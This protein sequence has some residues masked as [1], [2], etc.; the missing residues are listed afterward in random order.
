MT[1]QRW[2]SFLGHWWGIRHSK[3]DGSLEQLFH[4]FALIEDSDWAAVG[5]DQLL[6]RVDAERVEDRIRDIRGRYRALRGECTVLV[7]LAQHQPGLHPGPREEQRRGLTPVVAPRVLV[8][9][10]RA[11]EVAHHDQ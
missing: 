9:L 1:K 4:R 11:A 8:H 7:G 10:R 5:R 3:S 6:A 2:W